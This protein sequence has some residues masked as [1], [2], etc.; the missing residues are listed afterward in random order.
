[1]RASRLS[2]IDRTLRP[3]QEDLGRWGRRGG[4]GG[5]SRVSSAITIFSLRSAAW[6]CMPVTVWNIVAWLCSTA[7]M[8]LCPSPSGRRRSAS[9]RSKRSL[10]RALVPASTSMPFARPAS[11]WVSSGGSVAAGAGGDGGGWRWETLTASSSSGSTMGLDGPSNSTHSPSAAGQYPRI[12]VPRILGHGLVGSA[13]P[14]LG[15]L[16]PLPHLLRRPRFPSLERSARGRP[17]NEADPADVAVL[18]LPRLKGKERVRVERGPCRLAIRTPN[19]VVSPV[20]FV[21]AFLGRHAASIRPFP[22][23]SS[24]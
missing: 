8:R 2:M 1:M 3:R 11:A 13:A 7:A 9:S 15:D 17:A 4:G 10:V 20:G 6:A 12:L 24:G 5:G 21:Q 23:V 22:A 16:R 19:L 18:V 14:D